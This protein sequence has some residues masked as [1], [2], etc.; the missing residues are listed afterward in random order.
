MNVCRR[1]LLRT[2]ALSGL[3]LPFDRSGSAATAAL[4]PGFDGLADSLGNILPHRESATR[5]GR[6]YLDA[7]PDEKDLGMLIR[8][9]DITSA[10]ALCAATP[11]YTRKAL[12]E[13]H[14]SDFGAG[15]T[16]LLENCLMSRT[17]GRLCALLALV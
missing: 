4:N 10:D 17:E 16:V 6:T 3:L 5:V 11:E 12:W 13:R 15:R 14:C 8:L 2:I 7:F 1:D 9:L